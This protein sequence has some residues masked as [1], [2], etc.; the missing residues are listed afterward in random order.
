MN[1]AGPTAVER[2][3]TELLDDVEVIGAA[4]SPARS[5]CG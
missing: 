3:D 4:R 2:R 5:P 1:D